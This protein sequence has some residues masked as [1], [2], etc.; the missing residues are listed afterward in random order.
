MFDV[1]R[2][3]S[4]SSFDFGVGVDLGPST[5]R[6]SSCFCPSASDDAIGGGYYGRPQSLQ[7]APVGFVGGF[8][9]I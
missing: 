6:C 2:S 3:M 4:V 8:P 7:A 9:V 5:L 1:L